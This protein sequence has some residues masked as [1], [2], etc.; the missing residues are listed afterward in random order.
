MLR[1][2]LHEILHEILRALLLSASLLVGLTFL[3][4]LCHA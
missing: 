3:A 2:I 4:L 1:E